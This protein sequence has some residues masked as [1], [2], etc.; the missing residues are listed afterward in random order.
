[1]SRL[2]KIVCFSVLLLALSAGGHACAPGPRAFAPD[3]AGNGGGGGNDAATPMDPG[4]TL[5]APCADNASIACDGTR[6]TQKLLC[7]RGFWMS[8]G[9]CDSGEACAPDTGQCTA[10]VPACADLEYG[11]TFC[12]PGD[13]VHRCGPNL[14]SS[15]LVDAC[16]G[17][18]VD[19]ESS[20]TCASADCGDGKQQTS[21]ECDDGDYDNDDDC[22]E[23]CLPPTCGDGFVNGDAE[24]CDDGDHDNDDDCTELCLP[25]SCGDGLQQSSEQCDDANDNNDDDCTRLCLPPT[26]GDGFVNGDEDCDDKNDDGADGCTNDCAWGPYQISAGNSHTCVLMGDSTIRCLGQNDRGQ[27]GDGSG[28]MQNRPVPVDGL[29]DAIAVA[30]GGNQTFAILADRT[31]VGWGITQTGTEG[32]NYAFTPIDID[33]LAQVAAL[34]PGSYHS[35]AVDTEGLVTCWGR[36]DEGQVGGELSFDAPPTLVPVVT[37]ATAIALGT[38]HSCALDSDRTV[39]CWGGN[40]YDQLGND[41]IPGGSP[42]ST[43]P[44][45]NQVIALDAGIYSTCGLRNDGI[46]LCWGYGN[47]GQLG[48]DIAEASR[49]APEP[50]PG[51][52]GAVALSVN[53]HA[54]VIKSDASVQCWGPGTGAPDGAAVAIQGLSNV[55]AVAAGGGFDCAIK[56]DG[57]VAC[58]GLNDQGQLGDGTNDDS[59]T[60]VTVQF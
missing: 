33:F 15:E 32:N 51:I 26:C 8:N 56:S 2:T 25:P 12:G 55:V 16:E 43:V 46:P 38:F 50:V 21:E 5:D 57:S 11:D 52:T 44:G 40:G 6:P 3:D 42:P 35:C 48:E 7:S 34:A 29:S 19:G 60:P 31:V 37:N 47:D 14:V 17:R 18:C 59:A 22:T 1:M 28:T 41:T 45:L 30:A 10:I 39:Q 36:N 13:E 58:W 9:N 27:L 49:A 23:L 24:E 4:Q 54:C 20:A 53:G